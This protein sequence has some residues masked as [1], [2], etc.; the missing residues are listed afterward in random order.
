VAT[1]PR[2]IGKP[3]TP[4]AMLREL[5]EVGIHVQDVWDLVDSTEPYEPA[6]PVLARWLGEVERQISNVR[7]R[8][9]V[10]E[11]IVRALTVK[12]AR[13]KVA[14]ALLARLSTAETDGIRWAIGNACNVVATPED[15]D[16]VLTVLRTSGIFPAY[17]KGYVEAL[18]RIAIGHQDKVRGYLLGVLA[19]EHLQ[20][21]AVVALDALGI[22]DGVETVRATLLRDERSRV[23]S[24]A[25][26]YVASCDKRHS[27]TD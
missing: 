21:D 7:T 16:A 23:R 9:H 5:G 6:I 13:G 24:A 10:T 26:R 4:E 2:R 3:T 14:T 12:E 25:E 27:R 17:L 8:A 19:D 1:V 22:C 15:L 18:G 20:G 11:G